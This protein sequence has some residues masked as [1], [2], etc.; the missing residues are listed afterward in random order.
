M[1]S[2]DESHGDGVVVIKIGGAILSQPLDTFWDGVAEMMRTRRVIIVHGGGPE[3]TRVA[4]MIGHEPRIVRGRRVTTEIDLEIM[5]WVTR[6][7]LN[8]RLVGQAIAHGLRP[9]GLCGADAGM[10]VVERRPPWVIDGH[11]IDFGLVGDIVEVQPGL[12]LKLL[13]DAYLPIL[14]P[15]CVDNLGRLYNVNADTVAS[16]IAEHTNARSLLMVT[17]TGGLRRHADDP[18]SILGACDRSVYA[19]G[20]A[21]G[22]ISGGM[23]VKLHV[24][25]EALKVGIPEVWIVA[26]DDLLTRA[27]ATRIVD[28]Q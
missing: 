24:A 20:L 4:R 15:I 10:V 23:Q 12:L 7:S 19:S 3:A 1:S 28:P 25:L 27:T 13:D 21:D 16:A 2:G 22:W 8:T 5:Q 18:A 6:G 26:P 14:A 9:V 17:E 11:E